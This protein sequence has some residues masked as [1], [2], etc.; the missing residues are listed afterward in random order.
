MG[1]IA[2][3]P[4]FEVEFTRQ[5]T[6]HDEN[7][8]TQVLNFLSA[9]AV[10]DLLLMS[11]G[12]NNDMEEARALYRNFFAAIRRVMDAGAGHGLAARQLAVLGI[13]WPSKKFAEQELIPSG[14]ASAGSPISNAFLVRQ[15]DSLKGV[16]DK[17]DADVLLE[18]AKLL[19]PQLED[20]PSA[21]RAFADLIRSLPARRQGH[22]E[23]ASDRFFTPP[24]DEM[25][26]KLSRPALAAP[27][28]PAGTSGGASRLGAP[29][30]A[31]GTGGA[32][33][34]GQIF[35]GMKSAARNLLNYTT[36][37]QMK[38]RAG[39]VGR[40]GVNTLLRTL[41]ARFPTL[42][43]HLIGHSFGG[44]LVTAAADGPPDQPSVQPN[45]LTLL[46]AAFSHNGF[47]QHFDQVHDGFFRHV[48]TQHKVS[49]PIVIT[50][51]QNDTAVGLL[52][53]LAS[54]IAGQNA[55][56]LGDANDPYGG[57]GHN[58]AQHTPE[59]SQDVTVLQAV[60]S[61]Y[62]FQVGKLYNLNADACITG[63]SDICKD[64]MAYAVLAAIAVA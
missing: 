39:I 28:R 9:G 18:Q 64:E 59:V 26:R 33:G 2:G 61:A 37:Y 13:L 4:Y 20:S 62:P 57:I 27:P 1:D 5:G 51:T 55:S 29:G 24:G 42:K 10:T 58:G 47:A 3:Y 45:S 50:C 41:R 11:H 54:L 19:V 32:A 49:G 34:L 17:P 14:A 35:S 16:F 48:V 60:G 53:P 36:Y 12:W 56:K 8:V 31:P 44:R 38:E 63:H 15:L 6:L 23:D 40:S 22:P 46:Q 30:A 21:Q 25:M 43:L 52:Y 7:Q